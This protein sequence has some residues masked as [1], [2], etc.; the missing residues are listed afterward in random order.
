M[1][2]MSSNEIREMYLKYFESKGHLIVPSA[3][4]IPINDPTL[5]WINAGVTPLKKYFDGTSVP[6]NRRMT[7]SQKCIRTND[8]DNVGRTARHHTFF[9]ML[10]NFSIGDYFKKEAIAFSYELLTSEKYFGMDKDKLYMTIY[11]HDEDAYNLWIEQGVDPSHII[12][13]ET[14]FWEIGEGPS[15]PDSEIFYDRGVEYDPENKG[16]ALLQEEIDNDRYIEIW[17]NVFSMYNAKEGVAREN[18][19][20]LPSKNIDTGMGL[21]R[22]ASIMQ[23]TKTNFETDLFMPIIDE[24]SK[25]CNKPYNGEMAFKVIA[26]HIKALTFALSD[27]ATFSNEGRG[28]VL[29]RL[30]RR[31]VRFGKKLGIEKPFLYTLVQTVVNIMNTAY[32]YL[33]EK[34]ETVS[35]LV[36]REE[37]LFHKTLASGEQKLEELI[38]KT[39]SNVISGA[40]A[41]KLYDTY[42][43]PCELTKEYLE[44]KG[45]TIDQDAFDKCMLRQKEMARSAR[46]KEASMKVQ[47]EVLL[48]F[49]DESEFVGYDTYESES[50]VIALFKENELVNELTGEGYIVLDKTPFYAEMGG[51][52]ADTGVISGETFKVVIEDVIKAPHK[53]H[54]HYGDVDGTIKVGDTV[55]AKIDAER[56]ESI[57]KNHS[58][59]HLLQEALK[60]ALNADVMQAGSKVD[61]NNLR[62]DFTYQGKITDQEMV[63]AER[64]VNEKIGTKVDSTTETMSL[65]EAK[66]KGAVALFEEK[67]EDKVRVVT[68]YDSIELCG[69]THVKNVGDIN[70][71]AIK[72][73]E[74]K[75]S[76]VYR[77]EAATDKYIESELYSV[78]DPYNDEMLKLLGKAKRIIGEAHQEG[79]DLNFD[80]NIDNSAPA[81][82]ADIVYNRLEVANVRDKVRELEK[83]YVVAKEAKALEDLSSFDKDIFETSNGKFIVAKTENYEVSFLKQLVDRLLERVGTGLIFIANVTGSNV[84]YVA[85]AHK[86]LAEK[87]DCGALIKEASTKSSG[88][89]GGSKLFGQGG[90]SDIS[91]LDQI[92][93]DIKIKL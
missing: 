49:K 35:D 36:L 9:E 22:M 11:S 28:Y 46:S 50:K 19:K 78:I 15:G 62:F 18:Y 1:K 91:N 13:L 23:G 25:L 33:D 4:L 89:G 80:V 77:I 44:E 43:F 57:A 17:N 69:G 74:S 10:G 12:R 72:S 93:A 48:N 54:L 27:G 87:V 60:E 51:Q 82:Y 42:G 92:L 61:V 84:N 39:D 32:P 37:E 45:Y 3:S 88:N 8:I 76:N 83:A 5:L 29:R 71:F 65:E 67:Y 66:K 52:V 26:D 58:A 47:N 24:V 34:A 38:E 40:D 73:F 63:L 21:E 7:S 30:L 2:K 14:N 75:G 85:K 68:L 31:A 79:I 55:S 6:Q 86:D 56:R 90:G 53:Q 64:L 81:S 41:F 70:K 20:E 16:I 59:T